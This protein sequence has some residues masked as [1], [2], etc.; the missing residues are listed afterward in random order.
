M[1]SVPLPAAAAG[2]PSSLRIG[3]ILLYA[4]LTVGAIL[5]ILPFVWMVLTAF[6]NELEIAKFSW[7]PG[8]LRWRNFVEAMQSGPF[9]RYFRN[10]LLI[11]VGE[12]AF[13]LAVCTTAGYALAK[14][15]IRGSKALLNYFILLLLVPFQIILVPL[16]LIVK[17]IPLFGGNNI[18]GQGGIGWLNS[19]WGLI[20]P[21]GAAPLFTFLARQFFVSLPSELAQAARVDGLG[22]FGIFWR[23]MTP[24]IK[25]ALITICVFQIE[26]AWNGFLWPL[27]IT[28]SDSL[29]PLQLGLAIFA[30]NPAE[31]QWPYLMAGTALATLPMIVMFVLAQKRFVEGMA[32]VGIKG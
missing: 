22:E 3:R 7:L 31:V 25:P 13:T 17:S 29:R 2:K 10:S 21:L 11:A 32:N 24:L 12:T 18:L 27:M 30:Q 9:L 19:W 26:A 5:M 6:K 16:F 15:P 1:T 14:L 8:E 4:A 20:I 28:T 23:I